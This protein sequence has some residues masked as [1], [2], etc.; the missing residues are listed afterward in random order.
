LQVIIHVI[1]RVLLPDAE[2]LDDLL[3]KRAQAAAVR[4]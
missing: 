3:A 2:E 4:V 1:N